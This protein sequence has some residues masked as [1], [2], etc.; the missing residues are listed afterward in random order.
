[1]T[2][3]MCLLNLAAVQ[4]FGCSITRNG[5]ENTSESC[6]QML[7]YLALAVYSFHWYQ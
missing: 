4:G 5:Q 7:R 6:R 2:L 3:I 1:M